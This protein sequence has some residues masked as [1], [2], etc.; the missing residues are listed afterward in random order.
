MKVSK[1]NFSI[2]KLAGAAV[3]AATLMI[4]SACKNDDDFPP[5]RQAKIKVINGIFDHPA[6]V[7]KV[8]GKE[9]SNAAL[10]YRKSTDYTAVP[11]STQIITVT[12]QGSSSVVLTSRLK[13]AAGTSASFYLVPQT[14]ASK[15]TGLLIPDDLST[16]A[17]KKAKI[18]FVNLSPDAG[19]LDLLVNGKEVKSTNGT[20][21]LKFTD[22]VEIEPVAGATLELR[23]TGTQ[24]IVATN[25]NV[26][27][28]EGQFTTLWGVGTKKVAASAAS[29]LALGVIVNKPA[30]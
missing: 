22:F 21:F 8:N 19:K 16:I 5:L 26:T 9:L 23:E 25:T 24:N 6:Y 20:A 18:R 14:A 13:V 2:F 12:E 11:A 7:I 10:A 15:A 28:P 3:L 27:V 29:K 30:Q 17:E 4:G 1:N